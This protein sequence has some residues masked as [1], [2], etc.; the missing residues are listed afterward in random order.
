MILCVCVCVC[1]YV[2][3][4]SVSKSLR[5][6]GLSPPGSSVL[7]IVSYQSFKKCGPL[8]PSMFQ[9]LTKVSENPAPA[10]PTTSQRYLFSFPLSLLH[11]TKYNSLSYTEISFLVLPS[12]PKSLCHPPGRHSFMSILSFCICFGEHEQFPPMGALTASSALM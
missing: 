10:K 6:Y 11:N 3:H 4:S 7:G 8:R 1:V 5:S 2:S 12:Y 9:V